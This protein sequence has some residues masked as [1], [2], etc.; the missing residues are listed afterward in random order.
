MMDSLLTWLNARSPTDLRR[1]SLSSDASTTLGEVTPTPK[2]PPR[3]PLGKGGRRN[4]DS[5]GNGIGTLDELSFGDVSFD[6][7]S[8]GEV[9]FD[10]ASCDKAP[11]DEPLRGELSCNDP[12]FGER[13]GAEFAHAAQVTG[14]A[15]LIL[16]HRAR[17]D[18]PLPDAT[19]AALRRA[20]L[21]VAADNAYMEGELERIVGAFNEADIPVMVLKGVALNHTLYDRLD[22]RPMSDVDLLVHPND[23]DAATQVLEQTGC[24]RGLSLIRDDFFPRYY[25]ET[26]WLTGSAQPVRID[27]HVRPLRP[28]RIARTMPDVGLWAGAREIRLGASMA[29]VPRPELMLLHLAAH[30]AYHGCDRLIWLYDIKRWVDAYGTGMDWMLLTE[31]ARAWKLSLPVRRAA[32]RTAALFGPVF[33]ASVMNELRAHGAGWRDR[34]ALSHAPRDASSAV[35]HVGVNLFCTPGVRFRVGY[36]L[37]LMRPNNDHLA[38]IYS[39]RH[40]GWPVVAHTYRVFR[41]LASAAGLPWRWMVAMARRGAVR[42]AATG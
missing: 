41:A 23:V 28:L 17:Y 16:D 20:A 21:L 35:A 3:S 18:L 36:L 27:L 38:D 30:A 34:L 42:H 25:Y 15:G 1:N 40:W 13:F 11:C 22:M 8:C 14:L 9:S 4:G 5:T 31:R 7:V 32:E 2:N 39:G 26:E 37:A 24:R 12:S 29:Y 19:R 6:A 10:E 33:P